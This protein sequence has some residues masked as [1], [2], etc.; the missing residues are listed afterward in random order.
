M[1][2]QDQDY[3][4]ETIELLKDDRK[5]RPPE[6]RQLTEIF[7]SSCYAVLEYFKG[8]FKALRLRR[9]KQFIKEFWVQSLKQVF[10]EAS[11]NSHNRTESSIIINCPAGRIHISYW[12]GRLSIHRG[13][14][15]VSRDWTYFLFEYYYNFYP[16]NK[17][18]DPHK[19]YFGSTEALFVFHRCGRSAKLMQV[20]ALSRLVKAALLSLRD[21]LTGRVPRE[22]MDVFI[23]LKG[24]HNFLRPFLY[25]GE[26]IKK[27]NIFI[28]TDDIP[29]LALLLENQIRNSDGFWF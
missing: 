7:I 2:T 21:E 12:R 22:L 28:L 20:G 25:G 29:T 17:P 1:T 3:L 9:A 24:D 8:D 11:D 26:Q 27:G 15:V 4:Q 5:V 6:V 10:G 14:W 16:F 18:Y 19:E 23:G 13:A